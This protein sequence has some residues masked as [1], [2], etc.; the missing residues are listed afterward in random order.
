LTFGGYNTTQGQNYTLFNT[1][2]TAQISVN[3]KAITLSSSRLNGTYV[4]EQFHFHWGNFD[5]NGSEH[6][7]NGQ[8]FPL[9]LHLV[10]YNRDKYNNVSQAAGSNDSAALLVLG[11]FVEVAP[12]GV[13]PS[14][15]FDSIV[16]YLDQVRYRDNKTNIPAFPVETLLPCQ[17]TTIYTY[18]GSLTGPPCSQVV[19][20]NVFAKPVYMSSGSLTQLQ[21]KL[22]QLQASNP[23]E[24]I[25][26]NNRP[27]QLL[28]NRTVYE[29][30]IPSPC[31]TLAAPIVSTVATNVITTTSGV[32]TPHSRK[33]PAIIMLTLAVISRMVLS[34]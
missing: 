24:L 11:I 25:N 12:S 27:V 1:G 13:T 7:I 17:E 14:K 18:S 34:I 10:H 32:S 31:S 5:N 26:H 28:N 3:T 22:R 2:E 16:N 4:L 23:N 30:N 33:V 21:N 20:W 29:Y 15:A 8:S 9:E 19:N 6:R